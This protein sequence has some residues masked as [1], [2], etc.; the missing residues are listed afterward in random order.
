MSS[1]TPEQLAQIDA[2]VKCA[3][4]PVVGGTSD[5]APVVDQCV[6]PPT[7]PITFS[8][9]IAGEEPNVLFS[10][11]LASSDY[12]VQ[13]F[14]EVKDLSSTDTKDT[15]FLK[16]SVEDSM[17]DNLSKAQNFFTFALATSVV[18]VN[19]AKLL[20]TTEEDRKCD[21]DCTPADRIYFYGKKGIKYFS[22][23][24][25]LAYYGKSIYSLTKDG[26]PVKVDTTID[27][28]MPV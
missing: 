17:Q 18:A 19:A 4:P 3:V 6:T 7:S 10:H 16:L 8:K 9:L 22:I 11:T 26:E 5:P 20:T 1:F 23:G 24:L 13:R 25:A 21:A 2:L 12:A 27:P 14:A 15:L 28:N